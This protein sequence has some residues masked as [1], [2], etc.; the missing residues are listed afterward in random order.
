MLASLMLLSSVFLR[1]PPL[2]GLQLMWLIYVIIP[3][4]GISLI[5][6]PADGDYM[7]MLTGKRRKEKLKVSVI[8]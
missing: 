8:Y 2:T 4:V 7:R 5:G 6:G 1:P 3:L